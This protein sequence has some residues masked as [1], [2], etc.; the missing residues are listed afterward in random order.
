MGIKGKLTILVGM[1]IFGMIAIVCVGVFFFTDIRNSLDAISQLTDEQATILE[2]D[3]DAY[4]AFLAQRKAA[5]TLDRAILDA[6]D[7]DCQE[8]LQQVWERITGPGQHFTSEMQDD[9]N[10]FKEHYAAWKADSLAIVALSHKIISSDNARRTASAKS[11]ER[12]SGMRAHIDDINTSLENR[13][14]ALPPTDV[15]NMDAIHNA[16]ELTLNADRDAY[17]A[18]LA[19]LQLIAAVQT[20][21]T[22]TI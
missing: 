20:G 1:P 2:A 5:V 17:Q 13:L 9:F 12:F 18:Y 22:A 11:A 21:C 16:I 14:R 3:R 8:N 6:Q 15:K 19:Q 7:K 10:K 4:Q